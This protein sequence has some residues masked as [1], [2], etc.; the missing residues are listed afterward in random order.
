[1]SAAVSYARRITTAD[2]RQWYLSALR[3]SAGVMSGITYPTPDDVA[4]LC[5]ALE[6]LMNGGDVTY[7]DE[8]PQFFM[9]LDQERQ[10][11]LATLREEQSDADDEAD[12]LR[13]RIVELEKRL[14]AIDLVVRDALHPV[15]LLCV[16]VGC[17][18]PSPARPM[19]EACAARLAD[20]AASL[21][22]VGPG[23]KKGKK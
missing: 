1:M 16:N 11:A 15:A 3:M 18:E 9:D 23:P 6:D 8:L 22:K 7:A 17:Y 21:A 20:Q 13:E 14:E 10:D 5:E 2:L 4:N 12:K 19:C